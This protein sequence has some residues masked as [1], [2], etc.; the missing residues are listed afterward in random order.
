MVGLTEMLEAGAPTVARAMNAVRRYHE[1][2]DSSV[3]TQE[4]DR[5]REEAEAL[6]HELQDFQVGVIR[7]IGPGRH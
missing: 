1:A 6:M 7:K 3:P 4:V 2:R 5:L